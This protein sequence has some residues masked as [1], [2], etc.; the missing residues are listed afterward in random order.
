MP[1]G[2]SRALMGSQSWPQPSNLTF[3]SSPVSPWPPLRSRSTVF[4]P[5]QKTLR[6]KQML[7]LR[8]RDWRSLAFGPI[9]LEN[10]FRLEDIL[11]HCNAWYSLY[12]DGF[13][14]RD[15]EEAWQSVAVET[16]LL[17]GISQLDNYGHHRNPVA[18]DF[19]FVSPWLLGCSLHVHQLQTELENQYEELGR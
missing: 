14:H 12:W 16:G 18:K 7:S 17:S 15:N 4:S 13:W 8:G 5:S 2:L 9:S 1:P 10:S 6:G 19:V 11:I 3:T